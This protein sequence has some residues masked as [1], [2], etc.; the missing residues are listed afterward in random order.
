LLKEKDLIYTAK[1][2]GWYSVSDEAFYP[3]SAVQ[4]Q[5]DPPTGRKIMVSSCMGIFT[6][7]TDRFEDIYRDRK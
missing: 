7:I 2:E 4:L 1:H 6:H 5:I 3:Q